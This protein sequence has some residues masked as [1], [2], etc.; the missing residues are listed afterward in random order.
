MTERSTNVQMSKVNA[1][2]LSVMLKP[3]NKPLTRLA[4]SLGK[5]AYGLSP[6]NNKFQVTISGQS[7]ANL[8]KLIDTSVVVGL[9]KARMR[10][11][12]VNLISAPGLAKQAGVITEIEVVDGED[13]IGVSGGESSIV[14][15]NHGQSSYLSSV[16][17]QKLSPAVALE[18]H[19]T[20]FTTRSS[21]DSVLS[22]YTKS[23]SLH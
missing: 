5:L 14:G 6:Q 19:L 7:L 12:S 20:T 11:Q 2:L 4:E 1:P 16:N 9:L 8:A 23:I 18:G 15:I 17:K 22:M 21:I 3:E 13:S 10:N